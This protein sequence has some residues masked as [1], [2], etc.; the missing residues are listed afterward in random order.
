MKL[1][2]TMK[3]PDAVDDA[4]DKLACEIASEEKHVGGKA[5]VSFKNASAEHIR[6]RIKKFV[7]WSEYITVEIDLDAETAEVIPVDA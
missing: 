1:R 6:S 7:R 2:I 3:S 4:V 5:W